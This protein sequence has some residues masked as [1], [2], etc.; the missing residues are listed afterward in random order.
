MIEGGPVSLTDREAVAAC[1]RE[2][3]ASI[4]NRDLASLR[5]LLAPDFVHRTLGGPTVELEPFLEG[6]SGIPGEILSVELEEVVVDV[7]SAA[8]L[9]T[10]WQ[11]ARVRIDGKVVEDRRPFADWFVSQDGRWRLRVAIEPSHDS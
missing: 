5:Q 2:V 11:R 4:G 10:G 1:A 8:A 9:V 6:I 3:A 7:D